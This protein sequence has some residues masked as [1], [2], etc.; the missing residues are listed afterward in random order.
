MRA[1]LQ[2]L[3]A[4]GNVTRTNAV[5]ARRDII[6]TMKRMRDLNEDG[7][8]VHSGQMQFKQEGTSSK[9]MKR[10]R[11]LNEDGPA[12]H[13]VWNPRFRESERNLGFRESVR[14]RERPDLMLINENNE[15]WCLG[16]WSP[17]FLCPDKSRDMCPCLM[18]GAHVSQQGESL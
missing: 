1:N 11:D 13:S 4:R 6:Q 9:Q 14:M 16:R 12:V 5:Q 7:P 10:M 15:V 18:S 3:Q 2:L 17:L 8:A